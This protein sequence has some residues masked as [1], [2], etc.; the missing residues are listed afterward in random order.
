M[1]VITQ[2]A[3]H[4]LRLVMAFSYVSFISSDMTVLLTLRRRMIVITMFI[5]AFDHFLPSYSTS[6]SEES[7]LQNVFR[8][9]KA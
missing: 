1:V 7:C 9:L 6:T 4:E 5:L 2:L 8:T 3:V